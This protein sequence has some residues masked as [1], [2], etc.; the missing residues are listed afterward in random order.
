MKFD[1]QRKP[2]WAAGSYIDLILAAVCMQIVFLITTIWIGTKGA[3]FYNDN[4]SEIGYALRMQL[5]LGWMMCI[6]AGIGFSVLPLIYDVQGF[7]KTLMRIYVGLN[8]SGQMA[9]M[10]GIMSGDLSIFHSLSTI[11]ITLLCASLVCLWSPAM[12]IFKNKSSSDNSVGPF[13]YTLGALL[14]FLGIITLCCW[15]LRNNFSGILV[16]SE[17]LIYEFLIPL[18]ITTVIISHFNRRLNWRIIEAKNTGK[19]FAIFSLLLVF[20][21]ISEP[22]QERGDVSLRITAVLQFLPYL[23]IFVMLNPK[24]IVTQIRKQK[25]CNIMVLTSVFWLPLVGIAAYMETMG[26]LE[27]SNTMVS[28]KRWILIFGVA[29]QALWGF[30]AY[31][32]DDHKKLSMHQRKTHWF[33]FTSINLG[34]IITI[35]A[36]ISS[37]A[38][39]LSIKTYTRLAVAVYAL[40]YIFILI[41]W[42]KE[43]FFSLD[44]WHKIPMFY[45]QYLTNP[46]QNTWNNDES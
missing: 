32:H 1:L 43:T 16:L 11:G 10:A 38:N 46:E 45:D 42:I 30:V 19:I 6:I 44:N 40:S 39:D 12:T 23:F 41:H 27:T 3:N 22:L 37:W 36:M 9:I 13:S 33:A 28:Y 31:L 7:E 34:T 26:Y 18:V 17:N 21:F 5:G 20:S 4:L 35:Y 14:P 24:R 8:I 25:P 29:F 2:H 15:V